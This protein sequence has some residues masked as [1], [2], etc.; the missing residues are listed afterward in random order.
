MR[1]ALGLALA[2]CLIA[3]AAV[4]QPRLRAGGDHAN[5]GVHEITGL[6]DPLTVRVVS[7]GSYDVRS[8]ATAPSCRGNLTL[9][10]DLILRLTE[11]PTALRL[12]AR[13]SGDTTL[14]VRTPDGRWECDDDGGGN[15][16]PELRLEHPLEGQYDVWV[17]SYHP[18]QNLE[19][20]VTVEAHTP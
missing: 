9:E 18:E 15:T 17:G 5:Y 7:G 1:R 11:P 14:V 6:D 20:R 13:A 2:T 12:A 8:L 4:A 3:A 16:N 19:A 10:P